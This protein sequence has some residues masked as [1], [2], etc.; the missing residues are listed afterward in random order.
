[1][2][3][4]VKEATVAIADMNGAMKAKEGEAASFG[5]NITGVANA[6]HAI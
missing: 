1:M 5:L 6:P 4:G 2:T 3:D